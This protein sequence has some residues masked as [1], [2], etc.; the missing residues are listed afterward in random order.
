MNLFVRMGLFGGFTLDF[1]DAPVKVTSLRMQTL[2]A[3]LALHRTETPTRQRLA[4]LLW[5][6]SSESQS[7]TNLRTLL[8]RLHNILPKDV[9]LIRVDLQTI[10]WNPLAEISLDIA[11]FEKAI[12]RANEAAQSGDDSA[13]YEALAYAA[14]CYMGDFLPDCY[15]DWVLEARERLRQLLL[16]ALDQLVALLEQQRDYRAAITHAN[17]L[18][19]LDPLNEATYLTMMRLHTINGDRASALR[20]YHTCASTL[21]SELAIAP[22]SALRAAYERLLVAETQPA[23]DRLA[24]S[25][26]PL[27]GRERE[28]KRMQA[29]WNVAA[30]GQARLLI[31]SGEAGIGKTHLAE[32]LLRWANRQGILTAV[33]QCYPAEGDLAYAPLTALLRSDGLKSGL[34]RLGVEWRVEIA[35]L[36]PELVATPPPPLTQQWQRQRLFEALTRAVLATERPLLLLID[37]LQWCDR[38]TLEWMHFA[39]RF[40][41]GSRLLIIGTVR[42]EEITL[43]HPVVRLEDALRS[44]GRLAEIILSPLSRTETA[45]LAGHMGGRALNSEQADHLYAETE[46]NPLFVVETLRA[47]FKVEELEW[48]AN[49]ARS[50][51]DLP[52]RVRAVIS[53][54]LNQLSPVAHRLLDVA[55]VIGRSFTFEVLARAANVDEVGLVHGLDELW[56]RRI[57]REQGPDAYDFTHDKLRLVA[58]QELSTARQRILHRHVAE[59]LEAEFSGEPDAVSGQIAQHYERAGLPALAVPYYRRTAIFAQ[60]LYANEIAITHYRHALEL[61]GA[62]STMEKATLYDHLG[63]VLHFIGQYD[64]ARESWH[65]ALDTMP[66][67]ERLMRTNLYRKMGNAWR[68]QYHYDEALRTYDAAEAELGGLET[69][70]DEADWLCWGQIQLERMNVLYWLSQ[71]NEMLELIDRVELVFERYSSLIHQTRLSFM[72]VVG[73]LR[74]S[75]YTLSSQAASEARIYFR[76]IEEIGDP[77]ALPA[78]HFQLG[79]ALLLAEDNLPEAEQELHTALMLAER[80]GD[81]SLQ[82]RCLTYL[83][84]IARIR[85]QIEQTRNFGERSLRI[86]LAGQMYEY[87][88]AAH[89]NLAWLAWRE[90][91]IAAARVEGHKAV[92]AWRRLPAGYMFEWVGRWP[93]IGIALEDGEV[94]EALAQ[95]RVLLDDSQKRMP[96]PIEAALEAA[97]GTDD[98][99][100]GRAYLEIAA[101]SAREQGYL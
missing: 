23:D 13:T 48:Q 46:G 25:S 75:R 71:S 35:R 19:R 47:Q 7:L 28:W 37:D 20:V 2:L 64:E 9:S 57:L 90:G 54:R 80:T 74:K 92:E 22:G 26:A 77:N 96:P 39:L 15:D 42:S 81:I 14:A 52:P 94:D 100:T 5:P 18:M 4:F 70:S 76:A 72:R 45:E 86:A 33:A 69:E 51:I 27:V 38:D 73:L 56:Q 95:A 40:R 53:R 61:L 87:I 44:E 1:Q 67:N 11:D 88:G 32:D 93:L 10:T 85:G 31:L 89:G 97:V 79:F 66:Q 3:Y 55:A 68:D 63:E 16:T 50:M 83:T 101:A 59:A 43:E 34:A 60:R 58:Y 91:N 29:I 36:M 24:N 49:P 30:S 41:Q 6:D 98:R 84:V 78:A 17:R 62:E 21:Q 99:A 82:A 8:H 65:H 12:F